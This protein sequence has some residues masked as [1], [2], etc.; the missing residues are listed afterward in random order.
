M[1]GKNKKI[2]G[3]TKKRHRTRKKRVRRNAAGKEKHLSGQSTR[4][5]LRLDYK[6]GGRWWYHRTAVQGHAPI[7]NIAHGA[8]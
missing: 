3:R 1:A 6:G 7:G 4:T 8:R 5:L 2:R